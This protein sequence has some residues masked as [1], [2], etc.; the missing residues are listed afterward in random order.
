MKKKVFQNSFYVLWIKRWLNFLFS[1]NSQKFWETKSNYGLRYMHS[2]CSDGLEASKAAA[3]A[4]EYS[5]L[6]S[7]LRRASKRREGWVKEKEYK[8]TK[9][10]EEEEEARFETWVHEGGGWRRVYGPGYGK[11]ESY[12]QGGIEKERKVGLLLS[13][14]SGGFGSMPKPRL[15][16]LTSYPGFP[17]LFQRFHTPFSRLASFYSSEIVNDMTKKNTNYIDKKNNLPSSGFLFNW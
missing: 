2:I 8:E 4:Y 3:P 11:R 17:L 1:R 7:F 5:F 14:E 9:E 13:D 15:L 6:A 16:R 10:N 12:H